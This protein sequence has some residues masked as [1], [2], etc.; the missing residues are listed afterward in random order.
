ME[1]PPT[2][3]VGLSFRNSVRANDGAKVFNSGLLGSAGATP[4]S[5]AAVLG[6]G[7]DRTTSLEA[8][9]LL[10]L[11][12]LQGMPNL[13]L[14]GLGP[15]LPTSSSALSLTMSLPITSVKVRA[16]LF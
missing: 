14:L 2:R 6:V 13:A 3:E 10:E 5:A 4:T 1:G 12:H 7:I 16:A 9:S 15:A 8:L 11:P